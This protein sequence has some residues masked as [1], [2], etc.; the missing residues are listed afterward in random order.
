MAKSVWQVKNPVGSVGIISKEGLDIL[1]PEPLEV[2]VVP[3]HPGFEPVVQISEN[4]QNLVP[5]DLT[6]N[7]SLPADDLIPKIFLGLYF[8][9]V[10]FGCS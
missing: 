3:S 7:Q 6:N 2:S 8:K 5:D 4:V 9:I 10:Y 1:G